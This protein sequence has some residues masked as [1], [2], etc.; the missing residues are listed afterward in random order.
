M[1]PA[2]YPRLGPLF[3]EAWQDPGY[4]AELVSGDRGALQKH[5]DLDG[6]GPRVTVV[7]NSDR[8]LHLVVGNSH[9]PA[10]GHWTSE[11][12]SFHETCTH[13]L[14]APLNW[15]GRDPRATGRLRAAPVEWLESCGVAVPPGLDIDVHQNGESGLKIVIPRPPKATPGDLMKE[16]L[17]EGRVPPTIAH[18]ALLG[19]EDYDVLFE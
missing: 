5:F 17:R 19:L 8:T 13:P 18:A 12:R 2:R 11:V 10:S 15:I 7:A 4:L 6:D 1:S 14:L 3:L 9:I 16:R